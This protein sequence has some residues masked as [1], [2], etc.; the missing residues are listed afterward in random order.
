MNSFFTKKKPEKPGRTK[1]EPK[2]TVFPLVEALF[3]EKHSRRSKF[4]S[5]RGENLCFLWKHNIFLR[6]KASRGRKYMPARE[7]NICFSP[8]QMCVSMK[9]KYAF[10]MKAFIFSFRES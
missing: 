6:S 9:S 8:K 3:Y 5:S 4:V 10:L 1:T 2:S 7:A